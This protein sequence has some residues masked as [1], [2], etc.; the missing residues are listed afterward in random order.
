MIRDADV[1]IATEGD[2]RGPRHRLALLAEVL[3]EV[4]PPRLHAAATVR[5]S[6]RPRADAAELPRDR[7]PAARRTGL[8]SCDRH[9]WAQDA[10]P[11]HPAP[12]GGCDPQRPA[13][14]ASARPAGRMVCAG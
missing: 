10:G 4:Q 3:L 5:V 2:A 11:R 9:A 1:Q 6:G 13:N 7:G 8:V 14:R 12:R